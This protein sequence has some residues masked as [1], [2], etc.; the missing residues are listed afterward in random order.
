MK[1]AAC[2][3][4]FTVALPAWC[5]SSAAGNVGS[6]AATI[7]KSAASG[8]YDVGKGTAGALGNLATGHPINAATSLGKGVGKGGAHVA[9]GTGKGVAKMGK[10]AGMG[11]KKLLHL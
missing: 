7:G 1:Y 11:L 8:A 4:I 3:L 9:I 6:G 2:V 10:G 5:Q